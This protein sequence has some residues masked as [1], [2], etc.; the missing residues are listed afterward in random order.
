MTIIRQVVQ[1]P[2]KKCWAYVEAST[3]NN[4]RMILGDKE[5]ET[6]EE[7][8]AYSKGFEPFSYEWIDPNIKGNKESKLAPIGT[9]IELL[10]KHGGKIVSSNDLPTEEIRQARLSERMYVDEN[11]F[12]YIWIPHFKNGFPTT[13]TEV[14]L[15]EKY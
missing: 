5:F 3:E 7:A 13:E 6:E 11:S 4:V 9:L 15:F 1:H 8:I 14:E 2:I 12:G 10:A